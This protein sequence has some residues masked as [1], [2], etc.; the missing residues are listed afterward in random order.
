[1]KQENSV[2]ICNREKINIK[3]IIE[4]M[5]QESSLQISN[6]EKI[7][8]KLIIETVEGYEV[9]RHATK[10]L[11]LSFEDHMKQYDNLNDQNLLPICHRLCILLYLC[12]PCFLIFAGG[13]RPTLNISIEQPSKRQF[14]S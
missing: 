3:L 4:T 14:H 1:M 8:L 5:K 9:K 7:S 11:E 12:H 10:T 2:Q 6:R 13:V